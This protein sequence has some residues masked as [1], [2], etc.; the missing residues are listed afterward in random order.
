MTGTLHARKLGL[1]ARC[2]GKQYA[3]QIVPSFLFL[4]LYDPLLY[5]F[6]RSV[7]RV[8]YGFVIEIRQYRNDSETGGSRPPRPDTRILHIGE[9]FLRLMHSRMNGECW[10]RPD[11]AN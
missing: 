11:H 5:P 1:N 9:C 10:K 7:R 2:Y 8:F 6:K 3:V 4:L